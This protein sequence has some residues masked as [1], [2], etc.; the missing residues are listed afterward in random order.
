MEYN[1]RTI[2]R[3][4]RVVAIHYAHDATL[5][6]QWLIEKDMGNGLWVDESNGWI[7]FDSFD[8]I[9]E[10]L[11]QHFDKLKEDGQPVIPSLYRLT[12]A[13]RVEVGYFGSVEVVLLKGAKPV[14]TYVIQTLDTAND[15]TDLY[16]DLEGEPDTTFAT[17][18]LAVDELLTNFNDLNDEDMDFEAND[19]RIFQVA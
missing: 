11:A 7:T 8:D 19:Y 17:V 18:V 4:M 9:T 14:G 3:G 10:E 1:S 13:S 6:G 5:D 15:W 12:W 2:V 16:A